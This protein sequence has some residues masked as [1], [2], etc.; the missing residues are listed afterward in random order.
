MARRWTVT[1]STVATKLLIALTGLSLVLY[2][3]VHLAGNL[4]LLLGPATFN[5]YAHAL[6]S[7]PLIVPVEIGLAA[8]F[9]IHVYETIVMWFAN[10]RARPDPYE[11]KAWAGGPSR[12]SVASSTMIYTG[13]LTLA[14]VVLH[15]RTFRY[16]VVYRVPGTGE[17]DLY[18]L[19]LEVFRDPLAVVFYE[20]ALVLVGFHLWHGFTSALES[21]GLDHPRYTPLIVLAGRILAIAI[22]AGFLFIPLWVHFLGGAS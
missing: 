5:G 20:V 6:V 16:G 14:F 15:V 3:V 12:K 10:R 4:L 11:A 17:R 1:A 13:L 22:A 2:L 7:N 9:L 19:V 21:L 8:L 18:R